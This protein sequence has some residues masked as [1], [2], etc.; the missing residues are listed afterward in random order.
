[1][2]IDYLYNFNYNFKILSCSENNTELETR[3]KTYN[4]NAQRAEPTIIILSLV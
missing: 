2:W 4:P 3:V 1:M